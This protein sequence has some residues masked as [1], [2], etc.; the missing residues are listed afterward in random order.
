MLVARCRA[1]CCVVQLKE[2]K[3]P[4]SS[5]ISQRGIVGHVIIYPQR[6]ETLLSLLPPSLDDVGDMICI[7]FVGAHPPTREWLLQ[8]ARPLVV[9]KKRVVGALRWLAAHNPLYNGI[10]IDESVLA[11]LHEEDVLPYHIEHQLPSMAEDA[12]TS[13]YDAYEGHRLALQEGRDGQTGDAPG[14]EERWNAFAQELQAAALRHL[15]QH[16]R[17]F[18]Q[19]PHGARPMNEFYEPELLPLTYPTLFPYGTGGLE[20]RQRLATLS[21]ER[22]ARH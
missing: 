10:G 14:W 22:H 1:K 3:P 16:G 21:F 19:V 6:P 18:V 5:P 8:H 7:I 13:R 17:G 15:K 4:R 2:G 9:R 20:D 11:P 12:L